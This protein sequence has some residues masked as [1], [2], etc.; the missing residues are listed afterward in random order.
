M[1]FF[2]PPTKASKLSKTTK[3]PHH[4]YDSKNSPDCGVA[5]C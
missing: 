4:C 2:R 1:L 3:S 5:M